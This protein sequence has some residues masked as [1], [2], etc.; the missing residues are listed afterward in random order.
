[1]TYKSS[2]LGQSMLS[3]LKSIF[4]SKKNLGIQARSILN[5]FSQNNMPLS[6]YSYCAF[7]INVGTET[8]H[9][10]VLYRSAHAS[11]ADAEKLISEVA[12]FTFSSVFSE[13]GLPLTVTNLAEPSIQKNITKKIQDGARMLH[14]HIINVLPSISMRSW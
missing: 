5:S 7:Y 1:M 14:I 13:E 4:N 10:T 12:A 2:S 8:I 11:K 6:P 3:G 9:F